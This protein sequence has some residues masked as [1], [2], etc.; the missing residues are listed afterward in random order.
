ML[1][2]VSAARLVGTVVVATSTNAEDDVIEA[3]AER[4]GVPCHRGDPTDLLDRHVWTASAH[5]ADHVVKIPSD[6]PLIDP[7][8]IDAVLEAYLERESELDFASNLR[9]ATHPDGNDVEVFR[10]DALV[11]AWREAR[12]P[13]EREHTTPFIWSR[14]E[15]F[16]L[17]NVAWDTGRDC[18]RTHRVVLDY[19][20]DYDVIRAVYDALAAEDPLFSVNDVARYLDQ[21]RRV[22]E[23]NI[24]YHG[25][26]WYD[27]H[28]SELHLLDAQAS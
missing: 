26:Q 1:A 25:V 19:P 6:C 9:P 22:R 14:P 10:F 8:V 27:K 16:R 2:R 28:R 5:G 15:R 20:A 23:H 12:R 24:A 21:N 11:T 17:G 3:V 7:T 4:N 13:F 18:S